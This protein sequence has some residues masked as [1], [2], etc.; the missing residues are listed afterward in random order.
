MLLWNKLYYYKLYNYIKRNLYF[1]EHQKDS[2][3]PSKCASFSVCIFFFFLFDG[4]S[5]SV[6]ISTSPRFLWVIALSL[7]SHHYPETGWR[8]RI[9]GGNKRWSGTEEW[10]DCFQPAVVSREG[11]VSVRSAATGSEQT[12]R[13]I[14]EPSPRLLLLAFC[15]RLPPFAHA[16]TV[17]GH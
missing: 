10:G 13:L 1:S 7:H 8:R 16:C 2:E 14:H 3:F 15:S 9:E 4:V 5:L 6:L 12:R 17:R 11:A